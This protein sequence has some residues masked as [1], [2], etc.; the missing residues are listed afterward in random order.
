MRVWL[1][2]MLL[3]LVLVPVANGDKLDK[4]QKTDKLDAQMLLDLE[5]LSDESFTAHADGERRTGV[6][7]DSEMLDELDGLDD[8]RSDDSR[9]NDTGRR[10]R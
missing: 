2:T 3:S 10:R 1:A 5:L 6:S 7:R 4:L 9:S 8:D